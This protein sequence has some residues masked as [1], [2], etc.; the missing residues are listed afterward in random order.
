MTSLAIAEGWNMVG[1]GQRGGRASGAWRDIIV[2][3]TVATLLA[4]ALLLSIPNH[5]RRDVPVNLWSLSPAAGTHLH[6]KASGAGE[7]TGDEACS[8]RD[9]ANELC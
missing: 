7:S 9:Y 4:G 2:A 8:D 6:K 3:W 1:A 5:D